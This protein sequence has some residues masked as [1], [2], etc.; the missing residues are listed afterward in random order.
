LDGLPQGGGRLLS[1]AF[2]VLLTGRDELRR[3]SLYLGVVFLLTVAPLV[4]L[5]WALVVGGSSLVDAVEG[6]SRST[7]PSLADP[8]VPQV[9]RAS[10]FGAAIAVTAVIAGAGLVVTA[11]EGQALA[12]SLLAGRLAGRPLSI[13]AALIRSRAVFWRLLR[14]GLIVGIPLSILEYGIE[15]ALGLDRNPQEEGVTL[16]ATAARTLAGVPFVYLATGVV[17][18]DVGAF[19]AVRRSIR[20]AGARKGTALVVAVFAALA[21]YLLVLGLG[22]G[23]GLITRIAE[24][25]GLSPE[26]GPATVAVVSILLVVFVVAVGTLQFTVVAIATAPQVVAFLSLTR[27]TGGLDR[28]VAAATTPEQGAATGPVFGPDGRPNYWSAAPRPRPFLWLTI[29][30][31]IGVT[32]AVLGLA[33]GVAQIIGS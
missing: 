27:Y 19:E 9:L 30:L 13:R 21:Q 1:T 16:V 4:L 33:A 18:G 11:V 26:G 7:D 20:L 12:V 31:L 15:F 23:L 10:Q 32:I 14:A 8:T 22:E 17:L 3:G 2:D 6:L 5:A 29:P 24:P 28:A 25:L